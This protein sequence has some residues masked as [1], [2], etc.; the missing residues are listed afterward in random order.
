PFGSGWPP[1]CRMG[2]VPRIAGCGI[3]LGATAAIGR[4]AVQVTGRTRLHHLW[5][6]A[7]VGQSLD[8]AVDF[9]GYGIDGVAHVEDPFDVLS[10]ALGHSRANPVPEVLPG[11]RQLV[12]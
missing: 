7:D 4:G 12:L 3:Q 1:N 5:C 8:E 9:S 11:D 6:S 10:E 2:G